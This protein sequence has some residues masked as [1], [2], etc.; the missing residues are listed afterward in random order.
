M[1]VELIDRVD[2]FAELQHAWRDLLGDSDAASPFLTW[3]WLFSWWTHLAGTRRLAIVAVYDGGDLVAVAPFCAR[4]RM[5]FFER[6]EFL[7]TG[8]AGSD[9]LDAFVRHGREKNAAD[10]LADYI[11]DR[12]VAL[13]VSHLPSESVLARVA[14]PLSE[15]GWSVRQSVHG[16]CPFIR[17]EGH[18]W[19]SFLQTIGPAHRAT[20]RRRFRLLERKFNAR[21]DVVKEDALRQS[22]MGL[23]F[24]FHR[25]RFGDRGTAFQSPALRAF[26]LEATAR[27][28]E[29]GLLR[30]Y[31]LR[32]DRDVAAVMY[33]VA[34]KDRFYFF[35]HGHDP[36]FQ[37]LGV[38][39]A[40]LDMCIRAAIEEGLAEFDL[41]FGTEAYKSAWTDERH[42]LERIDVFPP[43]MAGRIHHQVVETE[44]TLRSLARRVV[45]AHAHQ[46]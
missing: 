1:R 40:L 4:R 2:R 33:G 44:R 24:E 23:L 27:W 34:F 5:S 3:E 42:A 6:W 45:S 46:T 18:D 37:S 7:G 14:V 13:R 15:S 21:F 25:M 41:L 38:G 10:A 35:Q 39:R 26:H 30:L 8:N 12:N 28:N 32:L 9:Y 29:S 36:R 17:L 11:R 19:E 31:T 16:V 43:H 22:A 20:T